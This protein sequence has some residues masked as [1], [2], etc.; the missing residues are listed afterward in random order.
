MSSR[1]DLSARGCPRVPNLMYPS[2]TRVLLS[3]LTTENGERG[4]D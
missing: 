1:G 2:R 3:V 4:R